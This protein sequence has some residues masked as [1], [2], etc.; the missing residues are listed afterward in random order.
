MS[1]K[2]KLN[3]KKPET[4]VT[5]KQNGQNPKSVELVAPENEREQEAAVA[6]TYMRPTV[7]AAAT[8]KGQYAGD[9]KVN[10]N[11]LID[12]LGT[13]SALVQKGDMGRAED[14]L[15][16]QAHALNALFAELVN[17]SRMNMGEYFPAACKFMQLAFKAQSQCRTAL[18]AL[19][20]IKNP[21]PVAFIRQQNVGENVQVNNG[22]I[23]ARVEQN[24]KSTNGL[25]EDKTHEQQWL[26]TGTAETAG[27][28]DQ[29]LEA[30]G[31][32]HR[33]ENQ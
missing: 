4:P 9:D 15:I 23:P 21:R 18:E 24:Q 12:E 13:Q 17:R 3:P 33:S 6:K 10:I 14:M 8:I 30:V 19:A 29:E 11:A 26:D 16:S 31:E 28:N 5:G 2:K 27:G 25:L 32:Q 1:K 22:H 7:L 20:E